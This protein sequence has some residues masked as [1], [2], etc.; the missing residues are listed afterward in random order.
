[1]TFK[2][3]NKGGEDWL[4]VW[5]LPLQPYGSIYQTCISPRFTL[6]LNLFLRKCFGKADS[7][8]SSSNDWWSR[9]KE[10][11]YTA[12]DQNWC[13]SE[14][15]KNLTSLTFF[16]CPEW[17]SWFALVGHRAF[18]TK[19][20]SRAIMVTVTKK[21]NSNES[22]EGKDRKYSMQDLWEKNVIKQIRGINSCSLG[23]WAIRLPCSGMKKENGAIAHTVSWLRKLV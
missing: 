21:P 9:K 19:D 23:Q 7:W 16:L 15:N 12:K 13:Y 6:I 2:Q 8:F 4:A 17:H 1:M 10:I 18:L 22:K 11:K 20:D 14:I 5:M 3:L